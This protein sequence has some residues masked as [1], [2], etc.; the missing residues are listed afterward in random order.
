M[1]INMLSFRKF[2]LLMVNLY[3]NIILKKIVNKMATLGGIES[4]MKEENIIV[5]A[6]I[7]LAIKAVS[8]RIHIIIFLFFQQL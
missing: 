3:Q 2:F 4:K 8:H 5:N 6:Q 7:K 1:A